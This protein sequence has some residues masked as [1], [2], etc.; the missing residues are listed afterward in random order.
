MG[1]VKESLLDEN[2]IPTLKETIIKNDNT[3]F[4]V[5][6]PE[7]EKEFQTYLNEK[8]IDDL[9]FYNKEL[10]TYEAKL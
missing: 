2:G 5:D 10:A 6:Y 7:V 8:W 9:E 1:I 4:L 3:I